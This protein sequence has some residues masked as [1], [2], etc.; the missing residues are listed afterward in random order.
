MRNGKMSVSILVLFCA[1]SVAQTP[2]IVTA[3]RGKYS[4][5]TT[6]EASFDLKIFWKVR[7]KTEEKSGTLMLAPGDRFR[8]ELGPTVWVSDGRTYW[9][10]STATQQV[11]IK[12]LLDVD[13][14]MHPSQIISTYL[15][16]YAYTVK[17]TGGRQTVLS[18]TRPPDAAN[19]YA[20]AI[21]VWV[22]TKKMILKKLHIVDTN[23]NESTYTFKKTKL[24]VEFPE[25]TFTLQIPEGASVLD[26][27]E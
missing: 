4:G 21:T 8:L 15:H 14:S 18:W 16:E 11:V 25:E 17:E 9:Q 6:L 7:E 12:Q 5:E 1:I 2:D 19:V 22:D 20:N 27:R 13:L 3:L 23:G 24:G 10:Y 26:T